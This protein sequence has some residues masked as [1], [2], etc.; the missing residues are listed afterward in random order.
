MAK[1]PSSYVSLA[2]DIQIHK[3]L[4]LVDVC[5]IFRYLFHFG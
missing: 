3:D 4:P 1:Q 2:V 5:N